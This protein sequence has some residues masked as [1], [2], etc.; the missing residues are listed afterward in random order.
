MVNT[1][2]QK[3]K[4]SN[5]AHLLAVGFGSGLSPVMP[6]TV[7]SLAAVPFWLLFCW[8]PYSAYWLLVV[9]AF[10]AGCWL[11]QKTAKETDTEDSGHIVWDEFVGMWICL[12]FIPQLAWPWVLLA[13]V[14][15]RVF[16][17]LKPWPIRWCD[18]NIHGG[19]GIMLDDVLAGLAAGLCLYVIGLILPYR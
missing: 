14:A 17:I 18:R 3:V 13:F 19:I 16:D 5:P 2:R 7:G 11:C 15:F 4:L 6:G 9:I 8:L 10:I 12:F 1:F